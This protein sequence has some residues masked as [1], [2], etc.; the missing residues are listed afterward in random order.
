M[1]RAVLAV[2]ALLALPVATAQAAGRWIPGDLH[3][4]T[5]YSHDSFGPPAELT[6]PSPEDAYTF[7]WT[8]GDQ[9]TL[10]KSRGLEYVAI[11]DHNDIRSQSDPGFATQG[12]VGIP[13]YEN[14]LKGHAQMLGARHL[15]DNGDKGTAAVRSLESALHA[16]SDHGIFQA[17]HPHDPL[18]E[19]G[20][21]VPV[22]TV[23][24]WNLPWYF[25]PPFPAASDNDSALRYWQGW[26]DRG[27]HVGV[28]GGSDNHYRATAA[29]QGVGQPTT[30]VYAKE[31]S[32]RG[33]LEGLRAGHTFVVHEPPAY[34]APAAFL[35]ADANR[36]GRYESMVGDTV[37]ATS[38][39]RVRVTQAPGSFLRIVTNGGKEAFAPVLVRGTNFEYRF[40]LPAK[41]TWVHAQVYGDNE[42][43]Q[44]ATGCS[45]V[46]GGDG[47]KTTTY[48]TNRTLMLAITSAIYLATPKPPGRARLAGFPHRCAARP[49]PARVIGRGMAR[50]T[51]RLDGRAVGPLRT[52]KR[53]AHYTLRIQPSQLRAG[54]HR[55]SGRV[56]FSATRSS[57][58]RS[59]SGRFRVCR[60]L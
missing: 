27:R 46:L 39:L 36:D 11:T 35:E 31:R 9:F 43:D 13:A 10:A 15:Y 50:I 38:A 24:A 1:T 54:P 56:T 37:P 23:E 16:S 22:D 47:A 34:G 32:V 45:A 29:A 4:H 53:G 25:Q 14:S 19:Y 57:A 26:L 18:W 17:N 60:N 48:C 30:W 7:G 2:C 42:S 6:P 41:A 5:T 52:V 44:K 28:T 51:L 33:I 21:D 58:P 49:F 59:V 40:K 8:V 20:Y 3:V 55:V 12:V